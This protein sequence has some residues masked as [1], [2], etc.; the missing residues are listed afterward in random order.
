MAISAE[1]L[2]A[3]LSEPTHLMLVAVH[4]GEIVAQCA[5]VIHRR[6]EKPDQL[7]VDEVGV[8]SALRRQGLARQLMSEMFAWG[9]ALG[10]QK[11]WLATELDNI[12]ALGLYRGFD[13]VSSK[14]VLFE[15]DLSALQKP[16]GASR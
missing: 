16:T 12:E 7:Y 11:S 6:P 13:G 10:C 14:V 4:E 15:Y 2:S 9:H 3:Y 8:T 5:A 1:R